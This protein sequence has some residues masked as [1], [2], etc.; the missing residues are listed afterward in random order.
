M[1]NM[2][3]LQFIPNLDLAG[4]EVMLQN[5]ATEIKRNNVDVYVVTLY[6]NRTV[7][8]ERL[9]NA[10]IKVI[11]L[12]KESNSIINLVRL[13]R[14][15]IRELRPSVIHTHRY[16][17]PYAFLASLGMRTKI[18]HT[19]HNVAEKEVGKLGL[20]LNRFLYKI[21]RIQF[22]SISPKV[23][24]SLSIRYHI[25]DLKIPMIYNG[26]DLSRCIKKASY[27]VSD[28][29]KI[30][31]IG[32]FG[33]QKNHSAMIDSYSEFLK[34]NRNSKLILVGDGDLFDEM[35]NKVIDLNI[36]SSVDFRGRLDNVFELLNECDV[37][38]L[39]SLWEGM[40]ITLI[41]AMGTGLPII[42]SDVGGVGDMITNEYEGE[43]FSLEDFD[44]T[45]R[46]IKL[47]G[48]L[49]LRQKYGRNAFEKSKEFSSANMAK[50]YMG[51]Y[52]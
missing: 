50:A 31:H 1:T 14:K 39:P 41:E 52:K 18:V 15:K 20:F 29:F 25:K 48:N 10:N 44:L 12:Q 16:V 9:E 33:T 37:F 43:L 19:V 46:I 13:L 4:A 30:L 28:E 40:P 2:S 35:K 5:L 8:H 22:V 36:S 17:L 38:I 51:L 23:R 49:E 47:H 6:S 27:D 21:K 45:N 7:I 11:S 3:V 32:R 34:Y 26:I 24:S 42:A